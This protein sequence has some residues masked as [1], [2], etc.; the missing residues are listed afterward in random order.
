MAEIIPNPFYESND[1]MQNAEDMRK[2]I[3]EMHNPP[4]QKTRK[5]TDKKIDLMVKQLPN[6]ILKIIWNIKKDEHL[7]K[8]SWQHVHN[9]CTD[10]GALVESS[11]NLLPY[12][13]KELRQG[14]FSR[15]FSRYARSTIQTELCKHLTGDLV[16]S[17]KKELHD[18]RVLVRST[19]LEAARNNYKAHHMLI[20]YL[21]DEPTGSTE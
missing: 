1:L 18:F 5:M 20:T 3:L 2:M 4:K 19:L 16:K 11:N 14:L 8:M 7:V 6:D 13:C 10:V 9:F 12:L 21:D 17:T 15:R